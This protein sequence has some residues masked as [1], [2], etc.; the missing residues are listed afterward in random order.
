MDSHK[1]LPKF[2]IKNFSQK[3]G[4]VFYYDLKKDAIKMKG[5]GALG[6]EE[7]YFSKQIETKLNKEVET[8]CSRILSKM[9]KESINNIKLSEKEEYDIK[10]FFSV[11]MFRSNFASEDF[12]Y[13]SIF[14][15]WL[16]DQITH[17]FLVDASLDGEIIEYVNCRS[18]SVLNNQSEISFVTSRN[19]YTIISANNFELIIMP[20]T[21]FRA[22]ALIPMDR[23][24]KNTIIPIP[25]PDDIKYINEQIA[26]FEYIY[27][28]DFIISTNKEELLRL[29]T[30]LKKKTDYLE[31]TKSELFL[32]HVQ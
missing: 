6:V 24:E 23:E 16:P 28:K 4:R 31:K 8:P 14:A 29:Q 18:V 15:Q 12:R 13:N 7:D 3:N 20:F 25:D 27:N 10:K 17:D 21:P 5:P 11:S 9:K 19:G 22:I 2:I 30:Y 32:N 26:S 1:Q